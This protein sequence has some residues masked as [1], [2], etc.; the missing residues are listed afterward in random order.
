MLEQLKHMAASVIDGIAW[1]QWFSSLFLFGQS[2]VAIQF[3]AGYPLR[4]RCG[5]NAAPCLY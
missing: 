4:A 1:G 3:A 2:P 5:V